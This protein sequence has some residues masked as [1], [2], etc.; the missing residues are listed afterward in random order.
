MDITP[1]E[2]WAVEL[3][4]EFGKDIPDDMPFVVDSEK[5]HDDKVLV[6]RVRK[7]IPALIN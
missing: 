6:I 4:R 5:T 3:I 1:L 2:K 7:P